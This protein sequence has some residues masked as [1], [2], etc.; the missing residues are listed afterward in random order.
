MPKYGP[1]EVLELKEI[2]K[3]T[4]KEDQVQVRVHATAVTSSDCI[5]RSG[6]VSITLWI[7]MR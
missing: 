6:K 3:P 1:P 7:P 5:V 2:E 4:V